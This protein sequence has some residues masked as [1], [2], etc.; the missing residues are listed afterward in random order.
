MGD[1]IMLRSVDHPKEGW[2]ERVWKHDKDT[3]LWLSVY[4]SCALAGP[5]IGVG[6]WWVWQFGLPY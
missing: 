4:A 3:L 2:F 5:L 1:N 6:G